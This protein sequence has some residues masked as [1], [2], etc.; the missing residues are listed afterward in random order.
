MF[1]V[2]SE[3]GTLE[4]DTINPDCLI[5]ISHVATFDFLLNPLFFGKSTEKSK[6]GFLK[7]RVLPVSVYK[8]EMARKISNLSA[9]ETQL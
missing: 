8:S 4:W 3:L 2:Y 5:R 9:S 7:L 1:V 6:T